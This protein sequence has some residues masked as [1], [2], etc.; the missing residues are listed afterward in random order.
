MEMH[1]SI[2]E[3]D[4]DSS[5]F[6]HNLLALT[7]AEYCSMTLYAADFWPQFSIKFS[8]TQRSVSATQFANPCTKCHRAMKTIM[9]HMERKYGRLE[10]E[11]ARE[12]IMAT[13]S[14]P[15]STSFSNPVRNVTIEDEDLPKKTATSCAIPR[16]ELDFKVVNSASF[17][18]PFWSVWLVE[19]VQ[20]CFLSGPW[21]RARPG[22]PVD[23]HREA[24][25]QEFQ[26]LGL[27]QPTKR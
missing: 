25:K 13:K 24:R 22:K 11:M 27:P 18:E 20:D 6:I 9:Q 17:P 16:K 3:N 7:L 14:L 15:C 4:Q 21:R 2:L 10:P 19:P 1:D 12:A 5:S 23:Q 26:G 8:L